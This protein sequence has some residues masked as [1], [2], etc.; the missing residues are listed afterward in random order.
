[1]NAKTHLEKAIVLNPDFAEA[2]FE[3]GMLLK[4]DGDIKES[5]KTLRKAV[6]INNDY[7]EAQCELAIALTI[8]D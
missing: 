1:M 8:D 4:E 5:I 7:A 3:L 2:Y 6:S